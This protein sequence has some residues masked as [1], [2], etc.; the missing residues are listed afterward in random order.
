LTARSSADQK[1]SVC[2]IE[3]PDISISIH[4]R[5]DQMGRPGATVM[6]GGTSDFTES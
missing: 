4:L 6:L 3:A 5:R 2:S 1:S